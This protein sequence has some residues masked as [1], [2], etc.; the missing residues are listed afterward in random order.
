MP[1]GLLWVLVVIVALVVLAAV[2]FFAWRSRRGRAPFE[3]RPIPTQQTNL[4]EG[5]MEELEKM[6]IAQPREAVAGARVL[7]DDVMTRMGY[8]VR[9]NEHERLQDLRHQHRHHMERYRTGLELRDGANTE[10][11]RRALRDYLDM[12]RDLL[13]GG[14]GERGASRTRRLAG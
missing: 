4:Y 11:L 5:R 3:V 2:V 13:R 8:P 9:V 6:F 10:Q 1:N 7:V 12:S 14:E